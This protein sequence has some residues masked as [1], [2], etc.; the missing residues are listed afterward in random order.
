M[1][2]VNKAIIIGNL[3]KDPEIRAIPDGTCVA[4]F[5]I[6]T[7]ETW[8]DKNTGQKQE[9]TEWHRCNA[10]GKLAEIIQMYVKKGLK[11]YVEG[12]IHTRKWSDQSGVERYSTE[13]KVMQMQMLDS[14]NNADQPTQAPQN[15]PQPAQNTPNNGQQGSI[16]APQTND[17]P[18]VDSDLDNI[19]F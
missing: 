18:F 12:S 19:P 4:N 10:F 5:S 17:Q 3:G 2:S 16:S 1:S 13:I 14:R 8:K 11:I 9:K 7:S 15:Q 6:A